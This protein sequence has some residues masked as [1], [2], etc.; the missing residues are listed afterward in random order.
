MVFLY[1][2]V[3][4]RLVVAQTVTHNCEHLS[5]RSHQ[6]VLTHL[7]SIKQLEFI[8]L[9]NYLMQAFIA[10]T[11]LLFVCEIVWSQINIIVT[12]WAKTSHVWIQTEINFIASAYIATLNNYACCSLPPLATVNWTA[13]PECFSDHDWWNSTNGWLQF[14]VFLNQACTGHRLAHA[15]FLKID[16]V[17]I[18]GM[19]ACMC[20]CPRPRLLI[21]SGMMWHDMKPIWLV[22]KFY[23]C[24]MAIAVGII[25]GRG[26]GINTLCGN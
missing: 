15:W 17:R 5:V 18:V 2:Q 24:Y 4:T 8:I 20:V 26:L 9:M 22:N 10:L 23:S 12:V 14:V 3:Q 19:C 11:D 7:R 6:L 1:C 13:F 16:L 21:T 25:N